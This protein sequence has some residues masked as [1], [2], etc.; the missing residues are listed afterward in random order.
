MAE[1]KMTF[2][3]WNIRGLGARIRLLLEYLGLPYEE[4]FYTHE[5]RPKWFEEEKLEL[6]KKNPAITLPYIMDGDNLISESDACAIYIIH[7]SGKKELLGRNADEQVA[8]ATMMGVFK[9]LYRTY[10][11][12][13]YGEHK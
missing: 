13:I 4:K 10:L 9:D 11:S 5:I 1:N 3:Y 8:V 7:K 2:C 6:I 12:L